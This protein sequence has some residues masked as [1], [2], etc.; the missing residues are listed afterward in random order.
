[1]KNK[2]IALISFVIFAALTFGRDSSGTPNG[3]KEEIQRTSLQFFLDHAH[4]VTGLVRDKAENFSEDGPENNVASI[5]S[6]GFA[7]A[8]ISHASLHG[9]VD[10]SFAKNY[11]AKTVRFMRDHVPKKFGWFLHWVNWETGERAWNSEYSTIDSA[12]F[13]GGALYAA[14]VFPGTECA[15]LAHQVYRETDFWAAMTDSGE[16]PEKR[17]INMAYIDGR[18]WIDGQWDMHAEQ[19]LLVILGLGHPDAPL[20]PESWLAFSRDTQ[21]LPGGEKVMGLQEALFVHQY[22]EVFIDFRGFNDPAGDYWENG[23]R[24]SQRHREI[25]KS[26]STHKTLQAGFWGFS[27]GES[28]TGYSVYSALNYQGTVCLGCTIASAMFLPEVVLSDLSDWMSSP[29]KQQIWGKYGFI[30]SI[31]LDQNWYSSRVL[32]ITAGPAY[33][34]LANITGDTSFWRHFMQVPEIKMGMKRARAASLYIDGE[35]M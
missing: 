30:D 23:V 2:S 3:I 20:P 12:L 18:G 31:D 29:Y 32:G 4:P 11:C 6:T 26:D 8:V 27:A 34:S 24:I 14:Q 1:M 25:A 13:L 21:E 7:L 15:K 16:R 22:S 10:Q 9:Q 19:K 5:A 17:A 33:M 35:V 28:P